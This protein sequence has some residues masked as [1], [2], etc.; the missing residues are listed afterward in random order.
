MSGAMS[1]AMSAQNSCLVEGFCA[2]SAAQM[3]QFA[4]LAKNGQA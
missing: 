1:G 4:G 3:I 2:L